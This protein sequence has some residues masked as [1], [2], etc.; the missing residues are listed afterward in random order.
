MLSLMKDFLSDKKETL[1]A[2]SPDLSS[3]ERLLVHEV[4]LFILLDTKC[5]SCL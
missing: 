3:Y 4:C 5:R 1:F 2:F